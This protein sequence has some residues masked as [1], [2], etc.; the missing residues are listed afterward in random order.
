[1]REK[2]K[3]GGITL[4]TVIDFDTNKTVKRADFV[5][6]TET[7]N[8]SNIKKQFNQKGYYP[9]ILDLSQN[10]LLGLR[11]FD[12]SILKYESFRDRKKAFLVKT[13]SMYDI[14]FYGKTGR[15]VLKK[16]EHSSAK[17]WYLCKKG[18]E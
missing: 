12:N 16:K 13:L 14:E 15:S 4:I 2:N 18:R 8:V 5:L 7:N 1:M 10:K 6:T 11:E 3:K 17:I 9:A